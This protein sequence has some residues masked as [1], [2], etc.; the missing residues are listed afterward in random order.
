L[1]VVGPKTIRR[2]VT[3]DE[4]I[5]LFVH[6][7]CRR[8]TMDNGRLVVGRSDADGRATRRGWQQ[9]RCRGVST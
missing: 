1:N 8:T 6:C 3:P 2:F 4:D 5:T 9:A 7:H